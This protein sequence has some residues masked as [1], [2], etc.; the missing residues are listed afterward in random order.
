MQADKGADLD[1]LVGCRGAASNGN[2]ISMNKIDLNGRCAAITGGAQG[3]GKAV[4]ER[5]LLSGAQVVLWDIDEQA[6]EAAA[7]G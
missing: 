5:L 4:A 3:S 2:G 1:F 7:G 6:L